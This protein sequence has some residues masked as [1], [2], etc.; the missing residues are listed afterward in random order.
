MR[1][2]LGVVGTVAGVLWLGAAGQ[3]ET[4]P[5]GFVRVHAGSGGMENPPR[6][7]RRQRDSGRGSRQARHLRRP[8]SGSR[9]T[10]LADRT[11]TPKI[12]TS[13]S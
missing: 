4:D 1:G 10:H 6:H 8:K 12:A 13:W 7:W 3:S 11:I 2:W 9:H 5:N